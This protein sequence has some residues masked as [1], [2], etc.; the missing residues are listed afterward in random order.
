[1]S[2][3]QLALKPLWRSVSFWV[4]TCV[5]LFL[6]WV[7]VDSTG[8]ST[9]FGIS[10]PP[11]AVEISLRNSTAVVGISL[12]DEPPSAGSGRWNWERRPEGYSELA[13]F[14]AADAIR[15]SRYT[16]PSPIGPPSATTPS[17]LVFDGSE[18]S[19]PFWWVVGAWLAVWL[20]ALRLYRKW[21]R[22]RLA[23]AGEAPCEVAG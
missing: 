10:Q 14:P 16:G 22:K 21:Q 9:S 19:I 7:W 5:T 11:R 1:M 20:G 2:S 3:A 13:W 17:I 8:H 6:L 12:P 18:F 4:G 23:S 15:V